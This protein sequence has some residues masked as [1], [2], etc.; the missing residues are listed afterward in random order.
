VGGWR[1]RREEFGHAGFRATL[2]A[3]RQGR[4]RQ[5]LPPLETL[6]RLTQ[7]N[8][9]LFRS[10]YESRRMALLARERWATFGMLFAGRR[11]AGWRFAVKLRYAD[12]S[13]GQSEHLWFEALGVRP[14]AVHAR[15]VSAPAFVRQLEAGS[16]AWHELERL[17]DWRV[18]TPSGVYD[19]ESADALFESAARTS[20]Y[21]NIPA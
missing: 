6:R 21:A 16:A 12:E 14:G 5:W 3:P 11:P 18:V 17:S 4:S 19:P 10:Q 1:T 8:A 9:T 2:V 20:A 15:L 13:T 7:A